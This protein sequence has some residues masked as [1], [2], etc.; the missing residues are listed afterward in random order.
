MNARDEN[1]SCE[2]PAGRRNMRQASCSSLRI[3]LAALC[4]AG[5]PHASPSTGEADQLRDEM[6]RR[7]MVDRGL[8]Y[9]FSIQNEGAVG[10]TRKKAVT[11]LFVLSCL[12][13]GI[14]PSHPEHGQSLKDAYNWIIK[15]SSAAFFGGREQPSHDHALAGL[16]L[17]ELVGT[18]A[19]QKEN[20]MLYEKARRALGYSQQIQDKGIGGDYFGGWRPNDRTKVNSRMLTT[21]YLLQLRSTQLR[22]MPVSKSSLA[23]AVEFVEAS[24]KLGKMEKANEKGGFSVDARGLP[25]LSATAAGTAVLSLFDPDKSRLSAA[26]NW[27]S[28]HPPQWYGPNFYESN[29]FAVCG[30]YRSRHSDRGEA[31]KKYFVRLSQMLK[32]RQ[33]P[34]GSWPFPPGHGGPILAM[35][36]GYSTAMAILI[37]NVDRGFLPMD[38]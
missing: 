20:Q 15:N 27:L 26:R 37:L 24:Q 33:E 22:G 14:Q 13:S 3:L 18:C 7:E 35:G 9:L 34:D 21:W 2:L 10:D 6:Q 31:Y 5:L 36:K 29:Y 38:Q 8:Q 17:T 1:R 4:L 16:M 30:L 12:S 28:R 11:S 19:V 32:E 23:R 25:V